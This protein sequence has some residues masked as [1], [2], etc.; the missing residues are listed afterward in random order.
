[1]QEEG[2]G[3]GAGLCVLLVVTVLAVR[4]HKNRSVHSLHTLSHARVTGALICFGVWVALAAYMAKMGSEAAARLITPY[5]PLLFGSLLLL[6]GSEALVRRRWW[7]A[8]AFVAALSALP[9]L[10]LSASR[11]L[12]PAQSI[13]GSLKQKHPGNPLLERAATVYGVYG[14]RADWGAALRKHFPAETREIG[15]VGDE[16]PETTLWRPFGTRRVLDLTRE[17]Q[18]ALLGGR[19]STVV[20]S[21]E[22]VREVLGCPLEQWLAEHRLQVVAREELVVKVTRGP[23]EWLVVKLKD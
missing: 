16:D 5:Y 18:S 2:A 20:V 3:A 10:I 4:G 9:A 6:R 7:K 13:C 15:F 12:W 19:V 17:N 23:Q 11:P 22:A 21:P 1:V 14:A 8:L